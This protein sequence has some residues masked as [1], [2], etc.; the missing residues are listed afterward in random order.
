[1]TAFVCAKTI[2]PPVVNKLI[3]Y[4]DWSHI[5]ATY[6]YYLSGVVKSAISFAL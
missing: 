1:M 6:A 2:C 3:V 4:S 5:T